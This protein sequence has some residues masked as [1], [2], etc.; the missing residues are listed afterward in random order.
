[1]IS[2]QVGDH[3]RVGPVNTPGN[4]NSYVHTEISWT[5]IEIVA[6]CDAGAGPGCVASSLCESFSDYYQSHVTS[7]PSKSGTPAGYF[8]KYNPCHKRKPGGE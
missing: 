3:P 7:V 2:R 6:W 8:I 1:M 4:I 5:T